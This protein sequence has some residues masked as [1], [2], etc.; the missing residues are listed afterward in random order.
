MLEGWEMKRRSRIPSGY[1]YQPLQGTVGCETKRAAQAEGKQVE[2]I[3]SKC[4]KTKA[5][6]VCTTACQITLC[7]I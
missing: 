2:Q 4:F 3:E 7:E 1:T 5:G 6:T